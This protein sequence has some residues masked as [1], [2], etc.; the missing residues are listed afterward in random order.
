MQKNK[1]ILL[2]TISFLMIFGLYN[3]SLA[4]EVNDY[5]CGTAAGQPSSTAPSSNLCNTSLGYSPGGSVTFVDASPLQSWWHWLCYKTSEG[6]LVHNCTAPY[7]GAAPINGQ[8]GSA[9]GQSFGPIAP[10]S[11]LCASGTFSSVLDNGSIYSWICSGVSYNSD[12]VKRKPITIANSG[13]TLTDYQ[14]K[15][16]VAYDSDMQADFD[17]IRFTSSDGSTQFNYWLES[18]TDSTI[19][20]FWVK[21]PSLANGNTDIYMYYG[22]ASATSNSNANN[23]F[24]FFDD[25]LGSTIDTNKWTIDSSTGFSVGGGLLTG[26]NSTGKIR[27]IQTFGSGVA[28]EIKEKLTTLATYGHTVGGF[29]ASTTNNITW[30]EHPNLMY[31][32]NN[33]S[34][35]SA[36]DIAPKAGVYHRYVLKTLRPT[37]PMTGV[38]M[39]AYDY[40]TNAMYWNLERRSNDVLNESIIIGRRAD[41]GYLN[42]AY[43]AVWDWV[44]VRNCAYFEPTVSV[45]SEEFNPIHDSCSAT[46]NNIGICGLANGVV[47]STAPENDSLCSGG[48]PSTLSGSDPWRWICSGYTV[49]DWYDALWTKRKSITVTS[50]VSLTNYQVALTIP[51]VSGMQADFDDLRFTTADRITEIN[52]WLESK[53]NS[54]SAKVW[55]KI[56]GLSVGSNTIYMYYGNSLAISTSNGDNTFDFFDD[57]NAIDINRDK[58][59]VA[60]ELP[61][62]GGVAYVNKNQGLWQ[63]TGIA[64]PTIFEIKYQRPSSYRNRTISY[65]FPSISDWGDFDSSLYWGEWTGT[66][67]SNNTWY[68]FRHIYDGAGTFY[69]K[70]N[71]YGG[72]E[73]FS[74]SA[75]Y[76]GTSA[77]LRYYCTENEN[78]R[79]RMDFVLARKY[80][81]TEPTFVLN[82]EEAQVQLTS[83]VSCSTATVPVCGSANGGEFYTEPTTNLCDLGYP[84][85]ISEATNT[86][87]WTCSSSYWYNSSWSKRKPIIISNLGSTLTDYQVNFTVTYDSDMQVDFDDL[88]FTSSDGL[89]ELN[90]W[91]ES[92]TDSTTASVWVKIPTLANGDNTIY[93]YYGNPSATSMSNG[94]NTFIFFDHFL[95]SQ[96]DTNKWSFTKGSLGNGNYSVASSVLTWTKIPFGIRATHT[97]LNSG[98]LTMRTYLSSPT[99]SGSGIVWA[100]PTTNSFNMWRDGNDNVQMYNTSTSTW[101]DVANFPTSYSIIDLKKSNDSLGIYING[102]KQGSSHDNT[103]SLST[104]NLGNAGYGSSVLTTANFRIDWLAVR[105][106][107]DSE[108]TNLFSSEETNV[109]N[110]TSCSASKLIAGPITESFQSPKQINSDDYCWYC[111]QYL[112]SGNIVPG[113]SGNLEFKFTYVDSDPGAKLIKYDFAISSGSDPDAPLFSDSVD[114]NLNPLSPGTVSYNNRVSVKRNGENSLMREIA[115]DTTYN[116]WIKVYNDDNKISDWIQAPSTFTTPPRAFPLVRIVPQKSNLALNESTL[117]CS[118]TNTLIRSTGGDCFNACWT[119][120]GDTA[121]LDPNNLDNGWNCSICYNSSQYP[122]LCSTA[123]SN[124]FTWS[125][126]SGPANLT[127]STNNNATITATD[128]GE[129]IRTRLLITGSDGC[130]GEQ[131]EG[132]GVSGSVPLPRW[133]EVPII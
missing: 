95:G 88:R 99:T 122:V 117:M 36:D 10:S 4:E 63:R 127:N 66:T 112:D 28:L 100:T 32:S 81:A 39:Y 77:T 3:I 108:P 45:G 19:A 84:S 14:V 27:S 16:V 26:T 46:K 98:T 41:D 102:V 58:W 92:K 76:S 106:A 114:L 109:I 93:M 20:T 126:V 133:K 59:G 21:V 43:N 128:V 111:N 35:S 86:W 116:W 85:I 60:G 54:T 82:S 125:L 8:C 124:S 44:F 29:W 129:E 52:Y 96:V 101:N 11:N 38:T 12:W 72:S 34:W 83:N 22:N 91:I 107:A 71:N 110:S 123:N 53:T 48:T 6:E 65:P 17:D 73:I 25:F 57:F 23:V 13:S 132:E 47:Y 64:M 33:T 37:D 80:T 2:T 30:L 105:E 1:I 119:G 51:F 24:I 74:R 118:T 103:N 9:N 40:D 15:V 78:S 89:T 87:D 104:I 18:K 94:D 49:S 31:H 79:I 97:S 56:P 50:A 130:A 70:I 61:I 62:S 7:A 75:S 131:G 55:V 5:A 68:L 69:W 42:A 67:L 115:Y 121:T 113:K 120:E 90:Y